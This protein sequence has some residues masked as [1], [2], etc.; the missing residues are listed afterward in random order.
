MA[1]KVINLGGSMAVTCGR[2]RRHI[3]A[4]PL[5]GRS[6][7]ALCDYPV[8]RKGKATTCSAGMCGAHRQ[9][10]NENRDHCPA[11]AKLHLS[12]EPAGATTATG[13]AGLQGTS[14]AASPTP[15]AGT[16]PTGG[17]PAARGTHSGGGAGGAG[18]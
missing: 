6:A 13:N 17:A 10:V 8:T 4:S 15:S 9:I 3:C 2:G 12:S 1:C 16:D 14:P 7:V 18:T 11:H 5:C